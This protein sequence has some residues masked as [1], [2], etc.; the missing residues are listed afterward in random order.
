MSFTIIPVT[1][2]ASVGGISSPYRVSFCVTDSGAGG[3][4]NFNCLGI[5]DPVVGAAVD[6]P[7]LFGAAWNSRGLAAAFRALQPGASST[8]A[9]AQLLAD[10]L[11]TIVPV[12]ANSQIPP[13]VGYLAATVA[14]VTVPFLKIQ[15]PAL[16]GEWR[17]DIQFRHSFLG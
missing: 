16:A 1:A 12:V 9:M 5:N 14:G 10:L 4:I 11:V 15:G 13:G 3:A 17:V 6:L 7:G 8:A 2:G